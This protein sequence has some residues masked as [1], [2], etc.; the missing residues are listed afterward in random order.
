MTWNHERLL[1]RGLAV[2]EGPRDAACPW[3]LSRRSGGVPCM[4][5]CDYGGALQVQDRSPQLRPAAS[6]CVCDWLRDATGLDCGDRSWICNAPLDVVTGKRC[7]VRANNDSWSCY[8]GTSS[9]SNCH[10]CQLMTKIAGPL[11]P[12]LAPWR[13][14][15]HDA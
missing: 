5:L 7:P 14:S 15:L 3:K 2:T 1:A 10:F 12:V 11:F 8:T 9:P 13:I 6:E 4:K